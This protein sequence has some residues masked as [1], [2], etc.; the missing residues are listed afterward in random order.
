[1]PKP[2]TAA[3][4]I[5]TH[6]RVGYLDRALATIVPQA[7][8]HNAQVLIVDDGDDDATRRLASTRGV[9]Y[10]Q[11]DGSPGLNAARNTAIA[12]TSAKLL[13]FV[14]DDVEVS[15][16]W[17][18][19]LIGA[20]NELPAEVGVLTGPIRPSLRDH[21]FRA[22]GREGPPITS[23]L[24]GD[25]DRDCPRAW[26][27]NMAIR[28]SAIDTI[29]AFDETI[30]PGDEE[31][32]QQRWLD[33]GGRIRYVA[34]AGLQ[35]VRYGDDS[36]L[37]SLCKAAYHR[38]R[39]ARRYDNLK[40]AIPTLRQELTT[41]AKCALHGPRHLCF[42][43]PVLTAHSLG[44]IAEA[45]NPTPTPARPGVD[46]FLSGA[47]GR[48]GGLHDFRRRLSDL[49]LDLVTIPRRSGLRREA[50]KTPPRAR[51]LVASLVNTAAENHSEAIRAELMRSRHEVVID[52][53]PVGARG[54]FDNL[55]EILAAHDLDSFDY[56]LA[57][58]DDIKLP[59]SFLDLLIHCAARGDLMLAQPAH[60]CLSHGAWA[61][62]RRT[63]AAWRE[64]TFVEIGP[65][66]LFARPTFK[67]LLPFPHGLRMGWGLDSHW[68]AVARRHDWKIGVVDVAAI[69]HSLRGIAIDYKRDEAI[70]EA[71]EFL[72]D[73]PYTP[74][75]EVRTL[76]THR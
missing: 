69:D 18:A 16:G 70:A 25:Q 6:Q 11:R 20:A 51:V 10:I 32:F 68:S 1:M 75:D 54:K 62:T 61:V 38:G 4:I 44:R 35:H 31:D 72:A 57:I 5:P 15:P 28:R 17:L 24:L 46:D 39:G 58:D 21:R 3:I 42:N 66:T 43:G 12:N 67:E 41:L 73:R 71:R 8:Q 50:G 14:D 27:A 7:R 23:L 53:R 52:M 2:L 64:T 45:R 59:P 60:R 19:A 74:R 49:W 30:Q 63:A 13:C 9:D 37:R 29:G 48:I 26:G 36:R 40:G 76:A 47:S 34:A 22:C 55:N 65:A 56:L 33:H